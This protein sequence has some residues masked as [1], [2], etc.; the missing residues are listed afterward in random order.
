MYMLQQ[1]VYSVTMNEE[2]TVY[3]VQCLSGTCSVVC[4]CQCQ[5]MCLGESKGAL[6]GWALMFLMACWKKLSLAALFVL[7]GSKGVC[8]TVTD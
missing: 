4:D 3:N 8:P 1:H 5:R 6:V 2:V 7:C